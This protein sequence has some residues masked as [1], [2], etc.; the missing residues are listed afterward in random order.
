MV[1]N[2]CFKEAY[3]KFFQVNIIFLVLIYG[4]NARSENL[5]SK[6]IQSQAEC[7]KSSAT[8]WSASLNR[9]VGKVEARNTRHEVQACDQI[10]DQNEKAECF[11]KVAEQ[12]SGL[13]SNPDSLS[14]G[15][16]NKSAVMN[17]VGTAILHWLE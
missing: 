13:N 6:I 14:D 16:T 11:K 9:C 10:I 12:K 1:Y 5:D 4:F 15:N 7:N 3:L 17:G 8:E 2:L